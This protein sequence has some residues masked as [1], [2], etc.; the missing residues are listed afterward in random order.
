MSLLSNGVEVL[1][2]LS[3]VDLI[4]LIGFP[5]FWIVMFLYFSIRAAIK[6]M[7]RTA[8]ID[9]IAKSPYLPR[10]I[11]EYG[12]WMF[13]LPIKLLMW[14]RVTPDMLTIGSLVVTIGAAIAMAMGY[15][16][17]G[18]WALFLGFMMDAWDGII[19]RERKM[20][21]ISGEFLDATVDRYNDIIAFL[22]FMFYYR[23]DPIPLALVTLSLIGSTLV[24]YTRAK[25]EAVGVDP[26]V[27]W[28]QR[29]ER[30]VYLGI[31]SVMAPLLS[32]FVEGGVPHPMFHLVWVAMAIMAFT[33]NVTAVWRAKFVLDGLRN[34]DVAPALKPA[35]DAVEE[36]KSETQL[37]AAS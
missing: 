37:K 16:C 8:R 33:T 34:K 22:G 18:G 25:G 31:S 13:T 10:I 14:L 28:M 6:G 15:F 2:R 7:P 5:A 24:S 21:S 35:N 12:Y 36:K 4:P 3:I 29:H 9:K 27:G 11:M 32:A 26:N 17:M 19:A 20:S 23:N 30:A 1:S